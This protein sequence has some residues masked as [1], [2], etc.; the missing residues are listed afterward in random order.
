MQRTLKGVLILRNLGKFREGRNCLFAFL[1]PF[2]G[3][4]KELVTTE[5]CMTA[6]PAILLYFSNLNKTLNNLSNLLKKQTTE[7]STKNVD[8]KERF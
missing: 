6:D 7:T 2:A 5:Y 3:Q 4:T 1:I 8:E